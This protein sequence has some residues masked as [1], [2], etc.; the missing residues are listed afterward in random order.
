MR[1]RLRTCCSL[2]LVLN[3][4][5][6]VGAEEFVNESARDI[7]VA[8]EVDVVVVGGGTGAVSAAVAAAD[9]GARVFLAAPHPYL[10]EDMTATLQLWLEEGEIPK[11]PLAVQL[12]S[13]PFVSGP[14]PNRIPFSYEA[15]VPS[16]AIHKDT[17][18]PQRLVDGKWGNAPSQSVQYDRDVT[19]VADLKKTREIRKACV[20]VFRR[21]PGGSGSNPF[22]VERITISLS[23]DKNSWQ[24]VAVIENDQPWD[25]MVTLAASFEGKARYVKLVAQKPEGFERMLLGE[26][27]I[28]GPE[29]ERDLAA[30]E[31]ATPPR[32]FHVKKTLDDA[33]LAAGVQYLYSCYATDVLRDAEGKPSGI[34]MANR[35]GR[36]AVV[37]KQ[38]IDATP[39]AIVARQAGASFSDYPAGTHVFKRVVV[40][41]ER[42]QPQGVE[43]RVISPPFQGPSGEFPIFEYTL[44]QDLNDDSYAAYMQADRE[45]R[46]QTYHKDQQYTSDVLFEVPPD[47]MHGNATSEG[48][49]NGVEALPIGAFQ[50]ANVDGLF[51]IGGCAGVS[52]D[53][54]KRLVRPLAQIDLGDRIGRAAADAAL[55]MKTPTGV[56]L[57]GQVTDKPVAEGDV[58]EML[59]GVRP[60]QETATTVPQDSRA[61]PVLGKYDVVVIGGGT[62]GAPAGIAAARR[63]AKTLV[64]EYLHGLGGVGTQG[65]VAGYYWGNR[66]GFTATVQEGQTRW[67]VEQKMEW[68]RENLLEAG[69]ELWLGT[70]GCGV[71]MKENRS[72]GAVV[73]TPYGRG[74]VLAH[75]VIDATGNS[76]I[77]AAAGAETIYTDATEFGM[78]GTGLPGRKLGGSYNNTDF[79]IVDETDMVD[80]WHVF[81]YS[82]EKY[83]TAFDHGRLIDTR[84][85]RR[86]VGDFTI[87]L[88]DEIN[89]RTFPDSVAYCWSN[90]DTHGYTIDPL[91]L[92]EHPEKVGMGVYIPW[93]A[94]LPKGIDGIVVTGLSI[95][96]HRDAVPLIRMQ[97]DIQNG[98]YAAGFAAALAA[99]ARVAIRDI[100]VKYL[101]EHLV[102]IGNLPENVLSD[103]DSYPLPDAK[104]SKAV[105]ELREGHGASVILTHPERSLPQLR[106]A[107]AAAEEKDK[108]TFAK[109]LAV[110]GDSRGLETI[111][112]ELQNATAWDEGW[113]YRGMGQFGAALSHLDAIICCM[114]RTRD[115]KAVPAILEKLE[116]LDATS[117]F[118]HHRAVGLALEQIGDPAAAQPLA[119]LLAKPDMT[120]HVHETVEVAK[121][122][123]APG[124]TNAEQ[125]RRES[126][127]E[128]MLA[129]ALYRCGDHNGL[130]EKILRQYTKDLRG[131]LARHAKAVLDEG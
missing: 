18:P 111:T 102:E 66:V 71:F 63:G 50:P 89:Q 17:T 74:V 70:L 29:K 56:R 93:R 19:I 94:M 30:F 16:A 28:V 54:A 69:G 78:Q 6:F 53:Q 83:P 24:Q 65:A 98:G 90:F 48:P 12:Y 118:S 115:S 37:A 31:T 80:V 7:P 88:A 44:R 101:Q 122:K 91:F 72:I 46:T 8:Y 130:G 2:L 14:D 87:T 128:L 57:P 34:V 13:D 58:R 41:G 92:L 127:R 20:M 121:Q 104:I 27:E 45:A 77:A 60:V 119:D 49:W 131:H 113:N 67:I 32:P 9:R 52:R 51:V 26:I 81:V 120:G 96:S 110:L 47:A 117:E 11:A 100:D 103:E 109:A 107:Y 73:A 3:L 33:L 99:E 36:Q 21:R 108:L 39:R 85:R 59:A 35:A 38:I 42:Q 15:D 23:D 64:V 126:L 61:L 84:E 75:T 25:S 123:G 86:I 5:A 129:R 76:D 79:T 112:A 114:G 62:G 1:N 4:S 40:G 116:L 124:G 68:F 10:G 82:K 106:A 55:G 43:T 105:Q 125:T 97:A 22:D 95:S